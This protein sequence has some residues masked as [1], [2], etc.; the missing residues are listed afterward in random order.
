MKES[1]HW[2]GSHSK[3]KASACKQ[4]QVKTLNSEQKTVG[5]QEGGGNW[6]KERKKKIGRNERREKHQSKQEK[7]DLHLTDVENGKL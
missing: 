7:F 4:R 2:A 5:T 6:R 3:S 1:R